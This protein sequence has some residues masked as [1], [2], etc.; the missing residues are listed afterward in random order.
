M[1]PRQKDRAMSEWEGGRLAGLGFVPE[2]LVWS[3][4]RGSFIHISLP[5]RSNKKYLVFGRLWAG[6]IDTA[7]RLT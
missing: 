4:I 1:R 6:W 3:P 7:K 2:R 5:S